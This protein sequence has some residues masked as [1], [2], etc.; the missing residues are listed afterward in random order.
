MKLDLRNYEI[1][2]HYNLELDLDLSNH[3]F[4][5]NYR[6]RRI[7]SCH[8]KMDIVVFEYIT[9]IS[10]TMHGEVVGACSYTNEDVLVKYHCKENM[11]FASDEDT[12]ADYY[13]PNDVFE[14]DPYLFALIDASVPLNIVKKGAKLPTSNE[15]YQ[16][17]SEEE[18]LKQKQKKTDSRWAQLDDIDLD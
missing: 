7:N 16:V 13:E 17:L 14:F 10:L 5:K 4:S 1:G 8:I 18:Y 15:G 9:D 6:I 12:V 3:E 2:K 11:S